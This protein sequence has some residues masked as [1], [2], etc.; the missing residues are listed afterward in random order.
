MGKNTGAE[1]FQPLSIR[2]LLK[3][4]LRNDFYEQYRKQ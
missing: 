2:Y 4:F 3:G 1:T